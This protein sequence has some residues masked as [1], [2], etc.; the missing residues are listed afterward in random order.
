MMEF[1][2]GLMM[3]EEGQGMTEYGLILGLLVVVIV[4]AFAGLTGQ[5]EGIMTALG[6]KIS[7]AASGVSAP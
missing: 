7:G 1:F 2:K 3:E 4:V 5:F 6:Q